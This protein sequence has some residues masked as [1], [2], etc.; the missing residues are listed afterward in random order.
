M[1]HKIFIFILFSSYSCNDEHNRA[2]RYCR[3]PVI[4]LASKAMVNNAQQRVASPCTIFGGGPTFN[5]RN[6]NENNRLN[7]NT[8]TISNNNNTNSN[9]APKMGR[10]LERMSSAPSIPLTPKSC[11]RKSCLHKPST[12]SVE[13]TDKDTNT[14]ATTKCSE[15]NG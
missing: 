15:N 13:L 4:T 11:L 10:R 6:E 5:N 8:N 9:L 3:P 1:N 7:S 14:Q 12:D 2:S